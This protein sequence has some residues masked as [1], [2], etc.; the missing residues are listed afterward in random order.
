M[1]SRLSCDVR[2]Q[3]DA[4]GL[5]RGGC[6]GEEGVADDPENAMQTRTLHNVRGCPGQSDLQH[7]YEHPLA[8]LLVRR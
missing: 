4:G 5:P 2:I 3:P 6:F 8:F 1:F 7:A